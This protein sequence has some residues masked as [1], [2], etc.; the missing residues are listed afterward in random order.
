[1]QIMPR[2]RA[3]VAQRRMRANRFPGETPSSQRRKRSI[4]ICSRRN[5][6]RVKADLTVLGLIHRFGMV[7]LNFAH[8][9]LYG[10]PV[11]ALSSSPWFYTAE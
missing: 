11:A 6:E 4:P 5:K 2:R 3:C 1:M 9:S 8:E 10:S 7:Q